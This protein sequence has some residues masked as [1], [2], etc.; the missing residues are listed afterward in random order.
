MRV[1]WFSISPSLYKNGSKYNGIGWIASLQKLMMMQPDI[2]LGIAF[3][4]N[5]NQRKIVQ[6]NVTYYP[7]DIYDNK[8][9]KLEH[10]FFYERCSKN[11][12]R[13]FLDVIDDFKPDV[14]HIFGS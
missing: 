2:D 10:L 11:D 7:I 12:I 3:V 9:K 14:I 4:T 8:L 13:C 6:D 1:L 5:D